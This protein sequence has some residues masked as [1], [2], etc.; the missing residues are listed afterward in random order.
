MVLYFGW[1]SARRWYTTDVVSVL[2]HYGVISNVQLLFLD[3]VNTIKCLF[4]VSFGC[5]LLRH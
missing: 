4:I 1:H 3:A 2:I 5:S